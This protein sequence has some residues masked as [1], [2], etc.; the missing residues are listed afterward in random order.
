MGAGHPSLT[1]PIEGRELTVTLPNPP[2]QG[3]GTNS[4]PSLTLPIEGREL[5]VTPP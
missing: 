5:T 4:H 3:E 1:L 2:H